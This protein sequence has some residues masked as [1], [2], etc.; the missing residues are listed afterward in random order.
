MTVFLAFILGVAA[1]FGNQQQ[2]QHLRSI[3]ANHE[4]LYFGQP[5]EMKGVSIGKKKFDFSFSPENRVEVLN[6]LELAVREVMAPL[7]GER[8]SVCLT[9]YINGM[10]VVAA[11]FDE[12]IHRIHAHIK[13]K[14][15]LIG[16]YNATRG[17]AKDVQRVILEKK[18]CVTVSMVSLQNF[19]GATFEY[20][21]RLHPR[22]LIL[23]LAHSEGGLLLDRAIEGLGEWGKEMAKK[24]LIIRTFGSIHA[25][26]N[27]RG[28]DVL[29]V[30]SDNDRAAFSFVKEKFHLPNHPFHFYPAFGMH[31]NN[32]HSFLGPT[33]QHAVAEQIDLVFQ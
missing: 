18:G 15:P 10:N 33:Y 14:A 4:D 26:T 20:F 25:L 9:C 27:D 23:M 31:G 5:T 28:K 7:L 11:E 2:N 1:L 32:D 6:I 13:G 21:S 24:H 30:Y 17:F 8:E 12:M 22:F 29:N 19:L 16:L 3:Q